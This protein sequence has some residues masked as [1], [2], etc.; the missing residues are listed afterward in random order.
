MVTALNVSDAH[1]F[2]L[3]SQGNVYTLTKLG[4][5]NGTNKL[6]VASLK[7]KVF[8]FEYGDAGGDR[9]QTLV[10]EVPFTYIPS[11][12][13]IIA[14]DA[15]NK[16][17]TADDFVVGITIA[18]HPDPRVTNA[19]NK[20]M[21]EMYFNIYSEWEP[22]S[23]FN[24]ENVA[25]NCFSLEL[26]FTP[27]HLYHTFL[28]SSK[29]I[30]WLL[31]GSDDKIHLYREDKMN[32]CYQETPLDE[33][34]PE[35]AELSAGIVMWMDVRYS[36]EQDRRISAVAFE[37][38]YLQLFVVDVA[39]G[40]I[41]ATHTK[42]YGGPLSSVKLF[43]LDDESLN[44]VV[45]STLTPSAIYMNVIQEGLENFHGLVDSGK[46]D[47][48]MCSLVAD[49]DMDG[50]PEIMIGTYGQEILLYKYVDGANSSKEWILKGQS[51]LSNPIYSLLY[52]DLTSDGM[53]E[54]VALTLKGVHI[55]Q[56]NID[57]IV[58][59]LEQRLKLYA[60]L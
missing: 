49:F 26:T 58:K 34:F 10:K 23:Q 41:I 45:T 15:F 4:M 44:L 21:S 35:L 9:K 30:V 60:D 16:S 33:L 24:L 1:Y 43:T 54:L 3:P 8:S 48:A 27:Y 31:S 13:E 25:Q 56:H 22:S 39:S 42:N 20:Q 47:C 19:G 50:S 36:M 11:G 29:E 59:L 28:P 6:L 52:L 51:T 55:M 53:N 37:N 12:A 40:T 32:H 5:T 38:G 7:R 46:Y 2:A 57:E 17:K 18:K 14:I